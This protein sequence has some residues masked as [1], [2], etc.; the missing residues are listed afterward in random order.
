MNLTRQVEI[1]MEPASLTNEFVYF[2]ETNVKSNPGKSS[3]KFRI[4][5]PQENLE[6]ILN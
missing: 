5:E 6:V 2:I 1:C 4:K 3:L